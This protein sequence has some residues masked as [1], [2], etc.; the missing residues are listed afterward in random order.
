MDFLLIKYIN[1][2]L[3]KHEKF[4]TSMNIFQKTRFE[5]RHGLSNL[6]CPQW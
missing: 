5:Q 4:N 3:L 2:N 1:I 6:N